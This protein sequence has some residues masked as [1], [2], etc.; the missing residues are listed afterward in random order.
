MNRRS[1]EKPVL[2]VQD[3]SVHFEIH[4]GSLLRSQTHVLKAVNGVSFDL[5]AG[6]T[7]GIVGESG[8]GKSTLARAVLGLI[9]PHRGRVMWL[10]Q[11]LTELDDDALRKKRKEFQI[12][13]QDPL[14]SLKLAARRHPRTRSN[15]T[16]AHSL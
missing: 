10:G 2:R 7:L 13:F 14:A 3:L 5:R 12:V 4:E 9:R 1:A 11:N 8:C 15:Q 6:E 16:P